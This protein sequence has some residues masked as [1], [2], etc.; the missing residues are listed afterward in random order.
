MAVIK[1]QFTLRLD[2]ETHVKIQKIAKNENRSLTN[3]IDYL[4]KS[5][6]RR[7]EQLHG[8]LIL[9]EEELSLK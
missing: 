3:M 2:V 7:Y 9:T 5:E 6:I 4:I 1:T 8:E